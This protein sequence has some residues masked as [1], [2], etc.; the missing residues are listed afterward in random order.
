MV[1]NGPGTSLGVQEPAYVS[2]PDPSNPP[3]WET[4]TQ[5]YGTPTIYAGA[6]PGTQDPD[7]LIQAAEGVNVTQ[8]FTRLCYIS[9]ANLPLANFGNRIPNMRAL[10]QFPILCEC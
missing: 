2:D 1:S 9:W 3:P 8:A 7:P 5:Y 6:G 10:I 4:M